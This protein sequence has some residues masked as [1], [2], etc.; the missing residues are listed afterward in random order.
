MCDM[1]T[2]MPFGA[3][4]DDIGG[5]LATRLQLVGRMPR[6]QHVEMIIGGRS[7]T[8][9]GESDTSKCLKV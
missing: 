3:G 1:P 5:V 6:G 9:L 7:F 2:A 8:D 4:G